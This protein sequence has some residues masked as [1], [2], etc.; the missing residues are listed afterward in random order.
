[1]QSICSRIFTRDQQSRLLGVWARDTL[2]LSAAQY[3]EKVQVYKQLQKVWA[4]QGV[5][6]AHPDAPAG[7]KWDQGNTVLIDDSKEK[8][9]AEPWNLVEVPEFLGPGKSEGEEDVLGQVE[10][11]VEEAKGWS[12]VS[13]FVKAMG[14]GF[15]IGG[16][17]K[18]EK[19]GGQPTMAPPAAD[20]EWLAEEEAMSAEEMEDAESYVEGGSDQEMSDDDE[21]EGSEDGGVQLPVS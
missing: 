5:Q 17:W 7:G 6:A 20:E 3:G 13:G 8:G 15:V 14:G 9:R 11:W 16:K 19:E 1:M 12:D 10:R 21:T 4:D 18:G 2:G